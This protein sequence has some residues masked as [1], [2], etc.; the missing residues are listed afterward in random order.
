MSA[1]IIIV[2]QMAQ[3]ELQKSAVLIRTGGVRVYPQKSKNKIFILMG[4]GRAMP[5][6]LCPCCKIY[7][8]T[9]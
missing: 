8:K 9:Q 1:K 5:L 4:G 7:E 3:F 6:K 2:I